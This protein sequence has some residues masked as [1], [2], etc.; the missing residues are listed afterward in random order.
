M[1]VVDKDNR[2]VG[3]I[4]VDDVLDVI[5][6]EATEDLQKMAAMQ[7][8]ETEYLKTSNWRLA[9]NRI[10]WLLILMISATLTGGIIQ[11]YESAL[12]SV[13]I[14]AAFIPMLMDTGGN[15]GSQ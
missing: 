12:Q 15:A 10:P 2:L 11:R 1:P 3:I 9:I 4:T 13:I 8:S 7:P 5:D 6:R 14:L